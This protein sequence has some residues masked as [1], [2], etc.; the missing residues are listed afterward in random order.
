[1]SMTGVPSI[2]SMRPICSLS[3]VIFK[4]FTRCSPNGLGRSG[5]LGEIIAEIAALNVFREGCRLSAPSPRIPPFRKLPL[6]S[7]N[8]FLSSE[9][10]IS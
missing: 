6:L 7:I 1:M 5:D 4:T 10:V 3:C 9:S 8:L 2:A